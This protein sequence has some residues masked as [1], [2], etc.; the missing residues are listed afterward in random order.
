MSTLYQFEDRIGLGVKMEH[1]DVSFRYM[2]YSNGSIVQPNDG[3]DIFI[4]TLG[5]RF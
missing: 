4:A 2:H 5:Y 3:M 1:V